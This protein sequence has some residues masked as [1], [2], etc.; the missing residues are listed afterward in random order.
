MKRALSHLKD[1]YTIA[2]PDSKRLQVIYLLGL[3]G[4]LAVIFISEFREWLG[5]G[6]WAIF[7]IYV[8]QQLAVKFDTLFYHRLFA[9][10]LFTVKPWFERLVVLLSPLL[11]QSYPAGYAWLHMRHHKYADMPGDPHPPVSEHRRKWNNLLFPFMTEPGPVEYKLVLP[12]MKRPLQA[13]IMKNY[14]LV[15]TVYASIILLISYK[16]FFIWVIGTQLATFGGAII[17]TYAHQNNSMATDD[18]HLKHP[19]NHKAVNIRFGASGEKYHWIHHTYPRRWNLHPEAD[20]GK[21]DQN[22]WI[23]DKLI[24]LGIAEVK[25][26]I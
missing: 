5:F 9:H 16:F 6:W 12:L 26:P 23:I 20:R 1:L 21:K 24:K 13:W 3:V 7:W 25:T 4:F 22:A 2:H 14:W 11:L 8:V 17:N 10:Q 18:L 19:Q 15:T